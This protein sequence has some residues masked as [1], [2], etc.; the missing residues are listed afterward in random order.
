MFREQGKLGR[1]VGAV[2]LTTVF[3]LAVPAQADTSGGLGSSRWLQWLDRLWQGGIAEMARN[4]TAEAP[5]ASSPGVLRAKE[6]TPT[7][8]TGCVGN[9]PPGGGQGPS[10]DPDGKPKP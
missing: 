1:I 8:P 9:P 10:T 5:R 2:A 7:N 4:W 3:S 6:C